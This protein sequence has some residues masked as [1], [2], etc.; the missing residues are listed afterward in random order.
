[1]LN[2]RCI[3]SLINAYI[4]VFCVLNFELFSATPAIV[5]YS[6]LNFSL[7]GIWSENNNLWVI[8]NLE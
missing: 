7:S 4:F 1:M 2:F 5:N 8:L 6:I 3:L